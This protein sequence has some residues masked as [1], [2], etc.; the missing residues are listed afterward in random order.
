[1]TGLLRRFVLGLA[2][3][4]LLAL[5]PGGAGS[6][7]A[8]APGDAS[9]PDT[10][11]LDAAVEQALDDNF[12]ARI[13]RN[14]V[15]IA[16]NNRSLGNAGFLPTLTGRASASE[17]RSSTEQTFLDGSTQDVDGASSR[18]ESATAELEWTLFNGLE[19]FATYD[20]LG[21]ELALQRAAAREEVEVVLADVVDAY[22]DVARQQQRLD[23]LRTGLSISR[24]RL[25]IARSR[26]ELGSASDL[27]VRRA[28]VD[29]NADSA[30]VLEQRATLTTAKN[31]LNRLLGRT[32]A[33]TD[34]AVAEQIALDTSLTLAAV[35][36]AAGE[37][38]PAL[39]AA[40][41][42][43]RAARAAEREV[44]ASFL[45]RLD[46]SLSYGYSDLNA[47]SGFL[48]SSTS[49][50]WTYGL[51]LTWDLFDGLNRTRRRA[52][53]DVRTRNARLRVDDVRSQLASELASTFE[54]Y[55]AR[56]QL[57]ELER[58]NLEAAV[59]NVEVALEQFR[60]GTITS[61]E[62]REVQE[63]RIEAE[64]RLLDA[65][66]QAKR[67]ETE[68]LRLSGRLLGRRAP[69]AAGGQ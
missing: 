5:L 45:P 52:N 46:A 16:A 1:M 30:A 47:E 19:R 26:R 2:A 54:D 36:R 58:N 20:R 27:E 33:A 8:Q 56:L 28:R 50:D 6:A 10:L 60:V 62:L 63:Q 22:T 48:R 69:G 39:Q 14:E 59:A 55:R 24:E 32:E 13:A 12:R 43:L 7:R 15:D 42:S 37:Q 57:I 29:L 49:T 38:N 51:S 25:S 17:T 41:R 23:L 18:R 65:R 21:A 4:F 61:V 67:A 64:G 68:L 34:Y 44:R 31:R 9:P 35:R 40:R 53:A 11:R 3:L 66:F